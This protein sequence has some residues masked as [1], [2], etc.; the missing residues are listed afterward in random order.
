MSIPTASPWQFKIEATDEEIRKL[1]AIFDA[2]ANNSSADFLRAHI[3]FRE[4]HN[5]PTNDI[6]DNNLLHVYEMIYQ[7]GDEEAKGHIE[8]MGILTNDKIE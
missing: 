2:N 6:H 5:D 7:L 1:R 4:Y 3:P 8:S